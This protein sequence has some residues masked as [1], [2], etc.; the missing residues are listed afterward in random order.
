MNRREYLAMGSIVVTGTLAGCSETSADDPDDSDDDNGTDEASGEPSFTDIGISTAE[1][2]TVD[3]EFT[4][5]VSATNEG[6]AAGD[7]TDELVATE[8]PID[9]EESVELT[10]VAPDETA[11][12]EFGPFTVDHVTEC[13][14]ELSE[15]GVDHELSI[16]PL[17]AAVGEALSLGDGLRATLTDVRYQSSL[18]YEEYVSAGLSSQ[19]AGRVFTSPDGI[20]LVVFELDF[21]NTGTSDVTVASDAFTFSESDFYTSLSGGQSLESATLESE[22][23]AARQLLLS[24]SETAGIWLLAQIETDA[25][26]TVTLDYQRDGASPA[27]LQWELPLEGDEPST[28]TFELVDVDAPSTASQSYELSATV[29]NTSDVDGT[30][31]GVLQYENGDDW[32]ELKTATQSRFE[33][34]IPAGE[35][36]EITAINEPS[37]SGEY[38]YRLAPF[39]EE[40]MTDLS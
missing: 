29:R 30:F 1:S 11:T 13:A 28:P 20:S 38:T 33:Y 12:A 21:E 40:W 31:R 22:P 27:D 8:G 7:Y 3:G 34:D 4:V 32:L 39:D 17:T 2:V 26:G 10:D 37:A 25:T 14:F 24:P 6:E 36:R 19:S 18:F 23:F 5:A 9:L 35:S 15:A 16:E